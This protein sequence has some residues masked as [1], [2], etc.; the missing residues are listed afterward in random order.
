MT[1]PHL[2]HP[3]DR[4]DVL[5]WGTYDNV[6]TLYQRPYEMLHA[7]EVNAWRDRLRDAYAR[8]PTLAHLRGYID[9]YSAWSWGNEADPDTIII[10][11]YVPLA[12]AL[13]RFAEVFP[14]IKVPPEVYDGPR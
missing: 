12:I 5:Y 10:M 4:H 8:R 7:K 11:G 2:G 3:D 1:R 13:E 14:G 6:R 9:G